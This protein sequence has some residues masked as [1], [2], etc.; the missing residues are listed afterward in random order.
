MP[1]VWQM[2]AVGLVPSELQARTL[3]AQ[4][5]LVGKVELGQQG[6]PALPQVQRP[7][8]HVPPPVVDE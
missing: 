7:A 5:V 6:S 4:P 1:H 8:V 2:V 3:F